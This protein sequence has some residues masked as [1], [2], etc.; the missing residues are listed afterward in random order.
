[1][2]ATRTHSLVPCNQMIGHAAHALPAL[3]GKCTVAHYTSHVACYM[4]HIAHHSSRITHHTSRITHHTSQVQRLVT[5]FGYKRATVLRALQK[6]NG[7]EQAALNLLLDEAVTPQADD[8]TPS[9]GGAAP[10]PPEGYY[11]N[12]ITGKTSLSQPPSDA[13]SPPP[14]PL[15]SMTCDA[16]AKSIESIGPA[17]KPFA[18][19]I[20]G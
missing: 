11:A 14:P 4:S 17:F 7:S 16:I 5:E 13:Q 20:V 19:Q 3:V 18:D 6:S 15:S 1:M 8:S 9:A 2:L 12:V 10:S